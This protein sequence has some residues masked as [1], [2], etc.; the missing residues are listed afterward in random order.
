MTRRILFLTVMLA[1]CG[2]PN[3]ENGYVSTVDHAAVTP[4]LSELPDGKRD[5]VINSAQAR[6]DPEQ[7]RRDLTP[8]ENDAEEGAAF[9]AAILGDAFS[10]THNADVGFENRFDETGSLQKMKKRHTVVEDAPSTLP[11]TVMQPS[12]LEV[13]PGLLLPWMK[14][15]PSSK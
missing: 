4:V 10:K 8:D 5:Q 11:V 15:A 3:I 6:P 7:R 14:V 2:G 1:A 12:E 13:T 9:G